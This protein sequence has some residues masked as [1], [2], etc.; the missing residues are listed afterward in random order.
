MSEASQAEALYEVM[1]GQGRRRIA[2]DLTLAEAEA[3]KAEFD[4]D[5]ARYGLMNP[6]TQ[7]HRQTYGRL[8]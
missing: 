7:I 4:R 8:R 1:G 5:C 3:V 6:P 2:A